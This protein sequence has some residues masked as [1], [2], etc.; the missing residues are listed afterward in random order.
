MA[1]VAKFYVADVT[2]HAYNKGHREIAM[3]PV[4]RGAPNAD[5]ASA[6][7]SGQI[8]LTVNNEVA[9]D[10]LDDF[11]HDFIITFEKV[12]R[13]EDPTDG[14]PFEPVD[15]IGHYA[16]GNCASCGRAKDQHTA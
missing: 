9:A 3:S 4:T 14:H 10:F 7:P 5:W 1:V 13:H 6:T 12:E 15:R 8:K 11:D 2:K 16:H